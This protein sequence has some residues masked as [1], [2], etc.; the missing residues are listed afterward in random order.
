MHDANEEPSK[1][2][3]QFSAYRDSITLEQKNIHLSAKVRSKNPLEVPKGIP[4]ESP[5]LN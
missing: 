3:S 1:N 4:H 2:I 5:L